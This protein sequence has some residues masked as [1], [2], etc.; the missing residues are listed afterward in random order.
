[1][2][3]FSISHIDFRP[4]RGKK[5][6]PVIAPR[7]PEGFK[8]WLAGQMLESA[9]GVEQTP[10]EE[11]PSGC[12]AGSSQVSQC[13]FNG[14]PGERDSVTPGKREPGVRRFFPDNP[15]AGF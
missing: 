6:S 14:T 9:G 15:R 7:L 4:R 13:H 3:P 5:N 12:T 2:P 11:Y 8:R 1:M 10:V